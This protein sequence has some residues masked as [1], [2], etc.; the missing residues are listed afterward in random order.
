MQFPFGTITIPSK[1]SKSE[2]RYHSVRATCLQR[3]MLGGNGDVGQVLRG[4]VQTQ[5]DT[6]WGS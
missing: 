3:Y 2:S 5:R 4:R 6:V 1:R